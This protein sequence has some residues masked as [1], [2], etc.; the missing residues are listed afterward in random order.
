M[1]IKKQSI[2]L[3][4]RWI[5]SFLIISVV[6][7]FL[8]T[9]AGSILKTAGAEGGCLD[10]PLCFGTFTPP[11]DQIARVEWLHRILIGLAGIFL[12]ISLTFIYKYYRNHQTIF[13]PLLLSFFLFLTQIVIG[14][15]FNGQKELYLSFVH[16]ILSFIT[17]GLVMIS[18]TNSI[19]IKIYN[20]NENLSFPKTKF[21]R[22]VI[23]TFFVLLSV[24][25]SG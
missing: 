17:L 4:E 11:S 7:L 2:S 24:I 5:I 8:A 18:L 19:Y 16:S 22:V 13:L 6:F 21:S 15:V 23:S 1:D 3:L 20:R 25:F 14:A 12:T 9:T 10:W